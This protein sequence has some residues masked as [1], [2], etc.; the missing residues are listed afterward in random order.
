MDIVVHAA[1]FDNVGCVDV[2]PLDGPKCGGGE[3]VVRATP[4][5]GDEWT[6]MTM[7][8]V[9]AAWHGVDGALSAYQVLRLWNWTI[10]PDKTIHYRLDNK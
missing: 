2:G 3:D 10:E 9:A 4:C 1:C 8:S 5:A 6:T 7:I